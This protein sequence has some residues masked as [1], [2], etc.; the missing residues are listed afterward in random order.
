M[1]HCKCFS[2]Y[3]VRRG[4]AGGLLRF[5]IRFE[6]DGFTLNFL[7]TFFS[8]TKIDKTYADFCGKLVI[9]IIMDENIK[10]IETTTDALKF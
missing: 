3:Y 10:Y 4:E 1:L 8:L 9:H 5:L 7:A 6:S 2:G